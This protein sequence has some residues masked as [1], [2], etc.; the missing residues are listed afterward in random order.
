MGHT[1]L[2]IGERAGE[3]GMP[4]ITH[5]EAVRQ[6]ELFGL[7][8]DE[9]ERFLVGSEAE[10]RAIIKAMERTKGVLPP[11]YTESLMPMSPEEGPPLP[12]KWGIRWP[13]K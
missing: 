7:S 9:A 13:W 11:F 5:E 2:N 6:L 10:K 8:R 3:I 4:T 1:R 12:R